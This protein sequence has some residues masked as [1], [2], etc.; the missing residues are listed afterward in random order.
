M[1][2]AGGLYF[3]QARRYDAGAGL[4]VLAAVGVSAG[5]GGVSGE[6]ANVT[7]GGSFINGFSNLLGF[8]IGDVSYIQTGVVY[9]GVQ[10]LQNHARDKMNSAENLKE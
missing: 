2:S 5:I 3:A 6:I 7:T 9:D 8:S 4:A 10:N 1:D